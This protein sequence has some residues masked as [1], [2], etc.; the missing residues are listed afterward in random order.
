MTKSIMGFVAHP[1][2]EFHNLSSLR[3]DIARGYIWLVTNSELMNYGFDDCIGVTPREEP[4]IGPDHFAIEAEQVTSIDQ[5]N[6][7]L[8]DLRTAYCYYDG[9][10]E[11]CY[12]TITIVTM[13]HVDEWPDLVNQVVATYMTTGTVNRD[14]IVIEG[15]QGLRKSAFMAT[16]N[17]H[18][19]IDEVGPR[20]CWEVISE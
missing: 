1:N 16:T 9:S 3:E 18:E 15:M 12:Y 13:D 11:S 17:N 20:R 14:A 4:T 19:P 5:I 10:R 8:V 2:N 7:A 6:P